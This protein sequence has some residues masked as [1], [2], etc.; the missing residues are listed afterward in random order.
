MIAF[1]KTG[2]G[3]DPLTGRATPITPAQRDEAGVDFVPEDE[4]KRNSRMDLFDQNAPAQPL[5]ARVRPAG[6]DEVIG[7]AHLLGSASPCGPCSVIRTR[8]P[9]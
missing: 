7:Q 5:A 6:V 2:A 1:P 9:V 3:Q 8:P 4:P